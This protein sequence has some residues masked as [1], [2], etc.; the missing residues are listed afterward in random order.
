MVETHELSA[1]ELARQIRDRKITSV[2]V[3][4]S[5][6]ERMDALEPSLDAWVR[7]DRETVLSDAQQRQTEL[8]SGAAT[9][10]LHGVPIGI[11]DIYHIA[12]IPTTAG[13]KVYADYVPD[14]TAVT[15]DLLRKAGAIMLG[16]TV[17]TEFACLGKP[18]PS[19]WAR[20]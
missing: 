18:G 17:T 2:E 20:R 8:E 12:G 6:L 14:E 10:P 16:K 9:G 15:I 5:F 7:V 4:Q 13:S 3:A 19:C 1:A 11:K